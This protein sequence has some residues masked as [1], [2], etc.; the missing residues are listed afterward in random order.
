MCKD[1]GMA[2]MELYIES[3]PGNVDKLKA[4]ADRLEVRWGDRQKHNTREQYA[5]VAV[6]LLYQ[7]GGTFE[8]TDELWDWGY[9]TIWQA[10]AGELVKPGA[11]HKEKGEL[12]D[13]WAHKIQQGIYALSEVLYQDFGIQ[14][15]CV[16][17]Q[18]GDQRIRVVT[19]D[20]DFVVNDNGETAVQV[21]QRRELD[22]AGGQMKAS[23]RKMAR[24]YG[25]EAAVN[26][27]LTSVNRHELL[28]EAQKAVES[29]MRLS[30]PVAAQF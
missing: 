21:W 24:L 25:P 13:E 10:M 15:L 12:A 6:R 23:T 28:K 1:D 5:S 22:R 26:V 2:G 19:V 14:V 4:S 3:E 11:N 16:P 29:K 18:K 30:G 9:R 20:P 17:R 27:A 8:F 7:C